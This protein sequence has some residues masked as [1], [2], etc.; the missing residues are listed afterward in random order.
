MISHR[1]L[2]ALRFP[3]PVPGLAAPV[4]PV[5]L[6]LACMLLAGCG[7]EQKK[8]PAARVAPVTVATVER[9]D[10]PY[11]L[12]A[13]GNVV[14]LASVEIKSRVG[15]IIE[16][17]LVTNGQDV[18]KGD[19]LFRVDPRAFDLAV[20][21]AEARLA[22]D[23]AQLVKARENLRRYSTLRDMNVV[24][25][26]Q[27]DDTYAEAAS[28]ESTI[29]LNE[30]ALAQARLDREYAAITAPISGRVG[31]IQVNEGNVIK[32]NDDRTLCVI[33]QIRP[34]NISFSLPERFLG[35]VMD[36]LAQGE[37]AVMVTPSRSQEEPVPARLTAVDNAV[38]TATGTIRL[39]AAYHNDD[40]RLWPGQ[41]VR[42]ELTLRTIAGALLLP[43]RAVLQGL[44]G[45]YV[46]VVRPDADD[47]GRGVAEARNVV[48]SHI[49]DERTVIESGLAEGELVVLDGQV[50]LAPGAVVAIKS[51]PAPAEPQAAPAGAESAQ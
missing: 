26:E 28:L 41:F 27:Y 38:D 43:T 1:S 8:A 32:A 50:G 48:T 5:C 40:N 39:L 20:L 17:Q 35:E 47:P 45:A 29:R 22:R 23:R 49:L 12:G 3:L 16:E 46:Y 6:L 4:A 2:R 37:L 31:I 44:E 42:V 25:Q 15:G 34:I 13:V 9:Q 11:T 7:A 51:A 33:N 30:A 21:E 10:V 19:L 24:A 18:Q 36:R 14:P